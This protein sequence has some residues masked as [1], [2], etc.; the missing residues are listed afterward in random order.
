MSKRPQILVIDGDILFYKASSVAQGGADFGEGVAVS[1]ADEDEAIR[2]FD[3]QV[4]Q[5]VGRRRFDEV[6]IAKSDDEANFRKELAP[7]YKAQRKALKKP[8]LLSFIKGYA[9]EEFNVIERKRIEA[10]DILGIMGTDPDT[11]VLLQS[12][13]KDLMQIPGF[14]LV[15]GKVVKVTPEEGELFFLTQ[16]LTGDT[17]DNYK[18]CPGIGP[19]KA[20]AIL[21]VDPD[22]RWECVVEAYEN[23]GLTEDDALLQARLARILRHGDYRDKDAKV[24]LRKP[25]VT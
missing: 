22:Y 11:K 3:K 17:V 18:G 24:R 16:V 25:N 21:D 1:W 2:S 12:A 6:I 9:K 8:E 5:L 15:D 13:D 23:A 19:V 7:F 20:A 10:D 14:H 4:K